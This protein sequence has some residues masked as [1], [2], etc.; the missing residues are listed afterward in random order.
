[1]PRALQNAVGNAAR[2]APAPPA[3]APACPHPG[4]G[5]ATKGGTGAGGGVAAYAYA[6]TRPSTPKSL[7]SAIHLR[8]VRQ[9]MHRP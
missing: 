1:M 9:E 8:Q 7:G 4:C 3:L 6:A 5:A 2:W